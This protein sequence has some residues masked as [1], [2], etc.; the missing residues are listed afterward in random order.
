MGRVLKALFADL[1]P[2]RIVA[3]RCERMLC[4]IRVGIPSA[5][6]YSNG[7]LTK[8]ENRKRWLCDTQPPLSSHP[9]PHPHPHQHGPPPRLSS[10]CQ[11][12]ITLCRENLCSRFVRS[13]CVGRKWH[14][15]AFSRRLSSTRC[16]GCLQH[17]T[18]GTLFKP[19]SAPV[20]LPPFRP[21]NC[22]TTVLQNFQRCEWFQPSPSPTV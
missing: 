14:F 1:R 19:S 20:F 21:L 6:A 3:R 17:S 2:Q 18:T 7:D 9:Y 4:W 22:I 5:G 12:R 8:T 10:L 15:K 16:V 11:P 13:R